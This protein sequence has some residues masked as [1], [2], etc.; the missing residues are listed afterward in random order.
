MSPGWLAACL[1]L[2]LVLP[3]SLSPWMYAPFHGYENAF[4]ASFLL[5]VI[6]LRVSEFC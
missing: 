5:F 6:G 3:L 2:S 1:F 4:L